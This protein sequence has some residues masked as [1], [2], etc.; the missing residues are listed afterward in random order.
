M[1]SGVTLE[2]N[3]VSNGYTLSNNANRL[4]P[5]EPSDPTW[6]VS[7]LREQYQAQGYLW[8]KNVLGRQEVLNF[9]EWYFEQFAATDLLAP[10][11]KPIDGIYSGLA[12]NDAEL[13]HRIMVGIVRQPEYSAFCQAAP[14]VRFYEAFLSGAVHL[15]QRKLIRY[16]KPGDPNCTGGHYDMVYL[17]QGSDAFCSSWI[18]IGDTSI[19]MGGLTYLENSH[20]LGFQLESQV[21]DPGLAGDWL[22]KDLPALAERANS[23]WLVAN[24]EA[25]DMVIHSPYIVHASTVNYSPENRMRLSTDIRYQLANAKIDTRWINDWSPDDML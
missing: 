12:I 9:R 4:G 2:L 16:T 14:I 21:S 11:S 23:R 15:Y 19:E 8:L 10:G 1:S 22:S 5:L 6:P 7:R 20:R 24:Y 25:G 17:R 3:L 18:P 13:I